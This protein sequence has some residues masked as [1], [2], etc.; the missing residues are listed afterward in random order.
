MAI[1]AFAIAN[2]VGWIIAAVVLISACVFAYWWWYSK[3]I[4][5]KRITDFELINGFYQP[6]YRDTAKVVKL[7]TGG[8]EVIYLKKRKVYRIAFGGRIGRNDYYFFIAPD[9]YPYSGL[10]SGHITTDGKVPVQ[11][12]NP[13]MRSQYTALEKQIEALH[14]AKK[15]FWDTYGN[16]VMSLAFLLIIGIL[17]WLIYREMHATMG[18]IA[19]VADKMSILADSMQ[20]MY[21]NS[22][23]GTAVLKPATV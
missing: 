10:L 1:D 23:G 22:Q 13:T 14:G 12:T 20:K 5:Y 19:G 3:K 6:A 2:T 4:F 16:W 11:T 8:F 15:S 18:S 9:G 21:V 17:A 7:G